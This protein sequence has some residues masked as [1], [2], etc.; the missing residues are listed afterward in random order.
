MMTVSKKM[1]SL[2]GKSEIK[3]NSHSRQE[4]RLLVDVVGEEEKCQ[5][6]INL[7]M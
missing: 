5:S 1:T 6:W 7:R 2:G 4:D 3:T